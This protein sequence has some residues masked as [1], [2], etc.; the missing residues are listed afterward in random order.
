VGDIIKPLWQVEIPTYGG[1]RL[2]K[3]AAN[4][5]TNSMM[6]NSELAEISM[7]HMF[8]KMTNISWDG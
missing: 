1:K 6:Q 4:T 3:Y 2:V 8:K 7:Y 5:M